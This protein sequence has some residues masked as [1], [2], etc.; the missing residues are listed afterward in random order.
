MEESFAHS[1]S[2]L[3]IRICKELLQIKRRKKSSI[4]K[5][6]KSYDRQFMEQETQTSDKHLQKEAQQ[7]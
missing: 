1:S 4:T 3:E 7:H 5:I 6:D 2:S